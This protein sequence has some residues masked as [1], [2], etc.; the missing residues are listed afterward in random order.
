M[1]GCELVGGPLLLTYTLVVLGQL[2]TKLIINS[3]V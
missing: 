1:E 3:L 2:D